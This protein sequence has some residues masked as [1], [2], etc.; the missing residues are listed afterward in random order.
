[1]VDDDW[2]KENKEDDDDDDDEEEEEDKKKGGTLLA[3]T[4]RRITSPSDTIIPNNN[5]SFK[6]L[7]FI[8]SRNIHKS[9]ITVCRWHESGKILMSCGLDKT[10]N[11]FSLETGNN[12]PELIK[13][14][15]INDLP[16]RCAAFTSDGEEIFI[17]GRKHFYIHLI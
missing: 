2:A 3:A 9:I 4:S 17:S 13:K 7:G 11:L 1:M 15:F 14:L 12:N 16:I 8:N 10:L 6:N 5:I